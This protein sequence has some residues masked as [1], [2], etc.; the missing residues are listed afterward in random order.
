[1]T[2]PVDDRIIDRIRKIQALAEGATT[3]GEAQAALCRLQNLLNKHGLDL[4]DII[5]SDEEEEVRQDC[6]EDMANKNSLKGRLALVIADNF[7]CRMYW[8]P[9]YDR[10]WAKRRAANA[11]HRIMFLGLETDVLLAKAAYTAA[12][13]VMERLRAKHIEERKQANAGWMPKETSREIGKS[14]RYGFVAG[15][16]DALE[17]NANH[18]ALV[19][20][21]DPKVD[22]WAQQNL[23]LRSGRKTH[24]DLYDRKGVAAGRAAGAAYGRDCKGS[25]LG[26]GPLEIEGGE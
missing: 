23:N 17:E 6:A 5:E 21:R 16:R 20:V 9:Y 8:E 3:E 7:R 19:L 25:K 10:G 13:L 1:M 22:G 14:F 15:L 11:R 18:M 12:L 2:P 24:I 26:N 4:S